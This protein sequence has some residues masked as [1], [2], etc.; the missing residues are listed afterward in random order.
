MTLNTHVKSSAKNF[1]TNTIEIGKP[2]LKPLKTTK[3]K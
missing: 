3:A 2:Y 1:L